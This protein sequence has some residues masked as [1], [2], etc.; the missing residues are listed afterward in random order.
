MPVSY[1]HLK[2]I[3][4]SSP[5]RAYSAPSSVSKAKRTSESKAESTEGGNAIENPP[6]SYTHLDVYKRQ[7]FDRSDEAYKRVFTC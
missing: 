3:A 5:P 1:T 2:S 7:L 6:V 4:R